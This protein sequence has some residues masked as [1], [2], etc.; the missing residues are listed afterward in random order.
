MRLSVGAVPGLASEA[1]TSGT[2][3]ARRAATG[4]GAWASVKQAT[5]RSTAATPARAIASIYPPIRAD[6][7]APVTDD[8]PRLI[9]VAMLIGGVWTLFSLRKSLLAGIRSGF[10]AARKS[11]GAT[12]L[13]ETERDLP[14]KWMLIALLL[15]V[16]PLLLLYQAIVG[17]WVVSIPMAVIMIV[18][19]FLFVCLTVPMARFTDWLAR[20]QGMHVSGGAV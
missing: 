4:G 16:L 13:A 19:G 7:T 11:A 18:A 17:N 14:M 2:P 10:A 3:A 8:L 1:T 20:R 12:P 9:G 6:A 15:F 5:G